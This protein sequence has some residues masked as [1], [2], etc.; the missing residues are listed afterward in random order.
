[1]ALALPDLAPD[2][3]LRTVALGA[4]LLGLS[5][6][7][8]GTYAVLRRESLLGDAMSHAALPGIALAFLLTHSKE[9]AL[10]LAGAVAAGW[11]GALLV[12]AI[13]RTTRVK[14]DTA[15]GLILS[16]FFGFGLVLLTF[17]QKQPDASQAGLDRFL[18]GQA[19]SLLRRDVM[20][21]GAGTVAVLL[22]VLL[23]WKE[24]KLLVFDPDFARV[25]GLRVRLLEVILTSMIVLAIVVGLQTVGVVL[26]SAMVVAPAA[27]A[28]QWTDRLGLMV[29]LSALF[30]VVAGMSG[31]LISSLTPRLPTG[32]TIVLAV[33]GLVLVSLLFAPNRGLV[34]NWARERGRR[35]Q[36]RAEGMLRQLA[37]LAEHHG[38]LEHGHP[39]AVLRASGWS[40]EQVEHVLHDLESAGYVRQVGADRWAITAAGM[41]RVRPAAEAENAGDAPARPAASGTEVTGEGQP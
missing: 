36:V 27:A 32:P 29:L 3:T 12:S 22:A 4:M 30:G 10:L 40:P 34:W 16:V 13:T 33:S 41:A 39:S 38:S 24:F 31:A 9:S 19:A 6:G 2:Y 35:G 11:L 21:M 8:V 14:L 28:R 20:V 15:L 1:M 26:M 5:S 7:V 25:L 17:I 37:A 23:L 18:F